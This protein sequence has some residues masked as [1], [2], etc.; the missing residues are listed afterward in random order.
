M[1][2]L[3]AI[4]RR[5]AK[6]MKL[7]GTPAIRV[8]K[9]KRGYAHTHEGYFTI[10]LWATQTHQAHTIAYVLHELS[11]FCNCLKYGARKWSM[12]GHGKDQRRVEA[13]AA[14][15]FGLRLIYQDGR[16][17]PK[18]IKHLESNRILCNGHGQVFTDTQQYS[19]PACLI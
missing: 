7:K 2:D 14:E 13:E 5:G 17:Y 18:L 12:R 1:L 8:I 9:A 10:P 3:Q 19:H 16:C 6:I 11:H 4:T 15:V